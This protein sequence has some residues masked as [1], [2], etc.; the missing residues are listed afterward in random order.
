MKDQAASLTRSKMVN[1]NYISLSGDSYFCRSNPNPYSTCSDSTPPGVECPL[2]TG[3]C[4]KG[5]IKSG[6]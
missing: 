2:L 6:K 4:E 1:D 3:S 5:L